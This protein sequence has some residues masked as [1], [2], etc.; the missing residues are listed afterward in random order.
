MSVGWRLSS[1]LEWRA[2]TTIDPARES[3]LTIALATPST[4]NSSAG[5]PVRFWN[6]STATE[7]F[8]REERG[9]NCGPAGLGASAASADKPSMDSTISSLGE[10][11]FWRGGR[12]K[13][14]L[15]RQR[16][17]GAAAALEE[18]MTDQRFEPPYLLRDRGLGAP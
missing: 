13:T 14:P 1:G 8:W 15:R 17:A 12:E 4:K 2:I 16:R 5:S 11:S 9:S 6:G 3:A 10:N 7:G 18:S